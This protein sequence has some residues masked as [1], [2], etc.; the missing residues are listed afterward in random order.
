[1]TQIDYNHTQISLRLTAKVLCDVTRHVT[2]FPH[3]NH[4]PSTF[5]IRHHFKMAAMLSIGQRA[6]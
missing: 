6:C 1:M 4:F 3:S 5:F 2:F